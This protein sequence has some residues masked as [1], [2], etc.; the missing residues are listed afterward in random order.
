MIWEQRSG[1][2]YSTLST[3]SESL[4]GKYMHCL[5]VQFLCPRTQNLSITILV[6]SVFRV[7]SETLGPSLCD[8]PWVKKQ[9]QTDLWGWES[10]HGSFHNSGYDELCPRLM[11]KLVL[12]E[13][14]PKLS[15]G[16]HFNTEWK[17]ESVAPTLPHLGDSAATAFTD[18]FIAFFM[19]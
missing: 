11:R 4:R 7:C 16:G 9:K 6:L 12:L 15:S 10:P 8:H 3:G 13:F 19:L 5:C 14:A 18:C 2:N 17:C 1:F